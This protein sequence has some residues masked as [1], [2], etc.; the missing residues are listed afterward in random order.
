MDTNFKPAGY[1]S[2]SPYFVIEGVPRMVELLEGIFNAKPL[3][4]YENPD[5][6]VMHLELQLD[7]SVI[8][9]GEASDAYPANTFMMH[10]YVPDVHATFK[11]AIDLGCKVIEAPVSKDGDPD[12]RGMFLDFAGNMWAVGTQNS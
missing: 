12:V 11:K 7:D 4:R 1:N 6:T 10:V 8:M 9:M 5:G 2:V 3:R